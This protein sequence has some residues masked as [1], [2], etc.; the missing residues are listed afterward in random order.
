MGLEAATFIGGLT[1][2]NPDATDQ[3]QQGDDHI[4]LIKAALLAT[5]PGLN[6]ALTVNAFLDTA[7]AAASLTAFLAALGFSAADQATADAGTDEAKWINSKVFQQAILNLYADQATA[8]AGVSAAKLMNPIRVKDAIY[9]LTEEVIGVTVTTGVVTTGTAKKTFWMPHAF[10]VTAV[11]AFL[12]TPQT[13]GTA[14]KVDINEA[15]VSIFDASALAWVNVVAQ[16]TA[17]TIND[18][19]LASGAKITVDVDTVGDGTAALLFINLKG[20]RT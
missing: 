9:A 13:S 16:A 15:G 7:L 18:P 8:Q 19:L 12:G 5:F 14:V 2:T 11:D 3:K 20:H 1:A 4:R 17:P 10:T 6:R